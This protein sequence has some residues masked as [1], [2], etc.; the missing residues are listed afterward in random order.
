VAHRLPAC[1]LACFSHRSG[2]TPRTFRVHTAFI[3][4]HTA[5][6]LSTVQVAALAQDMQAA[7]VDKL[8]L[9]EAIGRGGY[10]AVYRG[11]L[12][13]TIDGLR[14][15]AAPGVVVFADYWVACTV[16]SAHAQTCWGGAGV[17]R[18]DVSD[19]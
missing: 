3:C 9:L 17:E 13:C 8:Q 7:E 12:Q 2:C 6:T 16:L 15:L 14:W 11:E 19:S 10:G 4:G 1:L 18:G 5:F